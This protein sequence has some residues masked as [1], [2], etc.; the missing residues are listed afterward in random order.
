MPYETACELCEAWTGVSLRAPTA[1][2][3]TQAVAEGLTVLDVAPSREELLAKVAAV[4]M[5]QPWRPILVRAIEGADGPPRPETAKG[6]RPGRQKAKATRARWSGEWREATGCRCSRLAADRMVQGLSWHQGPTD[7]ATAA[8]RRHIQA[9]GLIPAEEVRVCEM[10]E[11]AR[12]SWKPAQALF[13][14]AVESLDSDHGRAPLHKVAALP[15]GT[16]PARQREWCEAALARRFYGEVPGVIWGLPWRKPADT[17]AAAEIGALRG[18]L[19]RHQERLDDRFAR[20]GGYPIG[21]GGIASANTCICQVRLKRSGAW[22]D[23]DQCQPDAGPALRQ[24]PWHLC[25]DL[26]PL[27]ATNPRSVRV[28]AP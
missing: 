22:W 2:E 28:K 5:G 13:P 9:A 26:Q 17:Q 3:M 21:S 16:H 8:A 7:E 27:P 24:L 20:T 23:C 11:G 4:A 25:Q 19:Q 1:Q 15:S 12:W 14:S 6:R 10:A 18:D